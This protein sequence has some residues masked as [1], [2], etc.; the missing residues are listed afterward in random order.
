MP[1]KMPALTK[2]YLFDFDGT[3]V[4]SMPYWA[5]TMLKILDDN[6]ISY[7]ENTINIITPLGLIGTAEYFI[8]LGLDKSKEEILA[9]MR[10]YLVPKYKEVIPAKEGVAHCLEVMKSLGI[11]LHILTASPHVFLDPCLKHNGIYGH[12]EN[13]WSCEDFGTGKTD[14]VIYL[15]A[16][17]RI[18]TSVDN[19]T[20]LDDNLNA[21]MTAV[22]AGMKVIGVY[23]DTSREAEA[24]IRASTHGYIRTFAELEEY[25]LQSF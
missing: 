8:S 12:F 21:D 22:S 25:L 9:L 24:Q 1:V 10:E 17:E 3:L 18:G 23:D 14:P 5:D 4:D 16:A 20:F 7:P 19:V 15:K 6:G 11:K 13:I 2:H